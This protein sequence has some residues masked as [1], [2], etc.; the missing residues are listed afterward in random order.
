MTIDEEARIANVVVITIILR[1][2]LDDSAVHFWWPEESENVANIGFDNLKHLQ[3][4]GHLFLTKS[5]MLS[6]Y[7]N[8]GTASANTTITETNSDNDQQPMD[9]L[10]TEV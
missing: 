10:L 5:R 6:S 9:V 7:D 4:P 3:K 8:I 2:L 1:R